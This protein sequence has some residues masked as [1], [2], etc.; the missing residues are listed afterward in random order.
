MKL[1]ATVTSERASKGQGGNIFLNFELQSADEI[2][3]LR[4][5]F[6][7]SP[8][9]K[10]KYGIYIPL[11]EGETWLLRQLLDAINQG[12]ARNEQKI[13]GEK[14]KGELTFEQQLANHKHDAITKFR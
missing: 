6:N 14:E 11:V 10:D 7:H 12:I 13:K 8:S 3:V 2:K 5:L 9:F 1:Y 4:I